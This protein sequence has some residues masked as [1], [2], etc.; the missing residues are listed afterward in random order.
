MIVSSLQI[1]LQNN[2]VHI[3]CV[4]EEDAHDTQLSK[5]LSLYFLFSK[6]YVVTSLSQTGSTSWNYDID[7][8]VPYI[9]S[10]FFSVS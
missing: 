5:V 4:T 8:S 9:I 1:T 3:C 6:E 7:V 10:V 2:R